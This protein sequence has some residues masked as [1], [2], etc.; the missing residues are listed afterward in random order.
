MIGFPVTRWSLVKRA[1]VG[2]QALETWIGLYWFPL[3]AWARHRGSRPEDA[4]DEVQV[5]VAKISRSQQLAK[6][7]P[8]RGRL[9]SWLLKAFSNHLA[10]SH[11]RNQRLKRGGST[12][13]VSIDWGSAETSYLTEYSHIVD[14]DRV[15]AR[16]WSL[17]VIEEAM[18][19]LSDHY[20]NSGRERLFQVLLPS[21]EASFSEKSYPEG[22]AE[23]EMTGPAIRQAATRFRQRYR[24]I[25]LDVAAKRLGITCEAQLHEELRD[26]LSG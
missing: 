22:V 14:P 15:Y 17:S 13:H 16:A 21:L 1:T 25:L 5:F 9:R 2:G 12:P 10:D 7:D 20:V 3:Y 26:L 23:L 18:E 6:A 24:R 4:A 8:A 19:A 11:R